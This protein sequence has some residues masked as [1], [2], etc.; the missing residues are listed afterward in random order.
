MRNEDNDSFQIAFNRNIILL[1]RIVT[2]LMRDMSIDLLEVL[3]KIKSTLNITYSLLRL[4]LQEGI[5][6][7]WWPDVTSLH[8]LWW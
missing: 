6:T 5:R 7:V 8:I 1:I 3:P 2:F 4:R